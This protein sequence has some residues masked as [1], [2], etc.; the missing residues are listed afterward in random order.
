MAGVY[1]DV[2]VLGSAGVAWIVELPRLPRP[3]EAVAWTNVHVE[4]GEAGGVMAEA[5]AHLGARVALFTQLGDDA[6]GRWLRER[7]STAG[8]E[9]RAARCAATSRSV[10]LSEVGGASSAVR[11]PVEPLRADG[12]E[13]AS[14][15]CLVVDAAPAAAGR[16]LPKLASGRLVLVGADPSRDARRLGQ[17]DVAVTRAPDG[18]GSSAERDAAQAAR[19]LVDAGAGE[20][21]ACLG[22]AG[23]VVARPTGFDHVPPPRVEPR[24]G[25]DA[26]A[27]SPRVCE[28][29]VWLF[30]G[31]LAARLAESASLLSAVRFANAAVALAARSA[32]VH[33]PPAR[34]SLEA[35]LGGA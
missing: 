17:V 3:G 23:A 19:D 31:A 16:A 26:R 15:R 32:P 20:A 35:L 6:E 13:L 5:A 22:A 25:E 9:V 8:I 2:A 7:W 1:A 28:R 18:V 14:A 34:S 21:V 4:A 10:V 12:L 29:E 30:A 11:A 33:R 27:A 24:S